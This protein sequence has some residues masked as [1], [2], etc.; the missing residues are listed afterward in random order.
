[1]IFI[2]M[3]RF[4]KHS[5]WNPLLAYKELEGA[6]QAL[7]RLSADND[8]HYDIYRAESITKELCDDIDVEAPTI[9]KERYVCDYLDCGKC[10]NWQMYETMCVGMGSCE[11]Y[12]NNKG[13]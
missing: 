1:M 5:Q 11:W 12:N 2:L 9:I 10:R 8:Y 6:Q 7:L 4:D 3:Q 13:E